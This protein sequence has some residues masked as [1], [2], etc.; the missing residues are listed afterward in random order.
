MSDPN[1]GEKKVGVPSRQLKS[2][3]EAAKPEEKPDEKLALEPTASEQSRETLLEQA[4]KFLQEDEVHDA[5]TDKK[6]AFLESK[7]VRTEEIH[8]LLGVTRNL[9]ASAPSTVR[10]LL[11]SLPASN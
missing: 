5:N 11:P 10:N 6:I 4:K 1:E 2:K 3:D 9:E 7:G 8:E